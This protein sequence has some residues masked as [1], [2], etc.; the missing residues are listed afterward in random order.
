MN[1]KEPKIACGVIG[2]LLSPMCR[3][4]EIVRNLGIQGIEGFGL[5]EVLPEDAN[6]KERLLAMNVSFV[7]SY[8]GASL[9]QPD[10]LA[11]ELDEFE[12]TVKEVARLGGSVVAVGGGRV[13]SGH[14]EK[15]WVQLIK[16][17]NQLGIIASRHG[18]KLGFH[19][20]DG[21]LIHKQKEV[22]RLLAETDPKNV[23]LTFDTAH[24]HEGGMEICAA[25]Q[26]Y[27]ARIV[28][29]HLKD[30][31]DKH[32]FVEIGKGTLPIPAFLDQLYTLGYDGWLTIELDATPDPPASAEVSIKWLKEVL[33]SLPATRKIS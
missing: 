30:V 5:D 6:L 1:R 32:Q 33:Q 13:I 31:N 11:D 19:P 2:W 24:F 7:G 23:G 17:I 9:V 12:M 3:V 26:S 27:Y 14:D 15:T 20:H 18:I 8:F 16:S 29:V 28:H 4:A 21:T 10:F 25:L 22:E